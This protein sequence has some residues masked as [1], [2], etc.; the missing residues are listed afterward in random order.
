M[1]IK[2]EERLFLV[3]LYSACSDHL[4]SIMFVSWYHSQE[5]THRFNDF[6]ISKDTQ[7]W[8]INA[9]HE[10]FKELSMHC[11]ERPTITD[12]S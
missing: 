6:M 5:D 11:P 9:I 3:M 7:I 10:L 12:T 4:G 8:R 1:S 2:M